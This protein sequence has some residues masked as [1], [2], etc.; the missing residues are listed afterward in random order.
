MS[1]E[2]HKLTRS[3]FDNLS[4]LAQATALVLEKRG[5]VWIIDDSEER[6]AETNPARIG[7]A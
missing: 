2:V 3:V 7:D 4:P 5:E 1:G 6:G